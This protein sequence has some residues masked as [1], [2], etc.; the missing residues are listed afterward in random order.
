MAGAPD[1]L[2]APDTG[3]FT[4]DRFGMFVHWGLYSLAARHEWVKTREKLTDEQYQVYFD[5][6]DPDR[7]DPVR[8]AR[9]AKAAGMRYVVLTTKHHDGFCL[10]DSRLTDY[11]VT[12]TPHGRDLVGPFV[13]ACRAEGLKVGFYHSLIDWHHPSFPVDGAHPRRDDEEFKAAAADRDI[14][15]YQ[16]YLHGQVRELLTDYGRIDYLF[17][18]FSYE[19]REWWG[20]KG[21]AD[22][23][24]AG[25]METVRALQPDILVNDRAGLPGDF[26]TPEQYQPS[27]PMTDNGRPVLWE[28]CQTLNGS[29]GYDRDNLDHKSA[30]LIIRMLVD[31]VSKGGNLLLNVGPTGRGDLDPRDTAVLAEVGR[32]MDLHERSVRGCGP[33]SYTP[34]ADCRY[35]Q[36]GDRLYVH[37]FAWPLRHLHLPGLEGRVR[38]AQLLNDASEITRVHLDPDRPA[39]NTQMGGQPAGTLTLRLPVQRPDTPVPVIELHLTDPSEHLPT[40]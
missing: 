4:T 30:D 29:W 40:V 17:F 28:A 27:A 2:P 11:K 9:T 38:Y 32:W 25:L 15:D 16:R 6:F 21:P 7:Y 36:R 23:D 20:G 31:G 3:W 1:P 14:R 22:W 8:W 34:P 26:V 24:S 13:E 39:I 18:D 12:R 35:T 10:W 19:G 33:S 5:H 37:L